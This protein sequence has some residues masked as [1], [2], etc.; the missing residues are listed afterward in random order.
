M[1][2]AAEQHRL[3]TREAR[4]PITIAEASISAASAMIASATVVV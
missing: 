2:D 3:Q 1:G 4:L